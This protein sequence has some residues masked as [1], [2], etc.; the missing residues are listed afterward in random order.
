M[1]V[2]SELTRS[3]TRVNLVWIIVKSTSVLEETTSINV[4]TRVLGKSSRSTEGVNGIRKSIN[5]ISVVERL[6]T[7]N[8]E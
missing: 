8:L 7:K 6:S 1:P 4:G 2:S 3:Q 5:G